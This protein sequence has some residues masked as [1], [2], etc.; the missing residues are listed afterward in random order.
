MKEYKGKGISV[1]AD[2]DVLHIKIMLMKTKS[3]YSDVSNVE[4]DPNALKE[5][6]TLT[7]HTA[8]LNVPCIITF[9]DRQRD[10]FFELYNIIKEKIASSV[11]DRERRAE[12]IRQ[13][14][15]EGI[16][17]CPKCVSISLT[18]DPITSA[19]VCMKCGHRFNPKAPR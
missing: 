17:Y 11:V 2:E 4:F 12:R 5:G 9:K 1:I 13:M 16:A 3:S 6:G 7:I 14:D 15:E 10:E 19:V 18:L 8:K